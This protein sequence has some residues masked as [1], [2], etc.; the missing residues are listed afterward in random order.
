MGRMGLVA[1]FKLDPNRKVYTFRQVPA[2]KLD[3]A[4]ACFRSVV[5]FVMWPTCSG[6]NV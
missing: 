1:P 2:A 3:A 4:S 5:I 6:H